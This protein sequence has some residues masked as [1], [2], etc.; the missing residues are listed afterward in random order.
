MRLAGQ[1]LLFLLYPDG[2]ALSRRGF[3]DRLSMLL[4]GLSESHRYTTHSFRTGAATAA[5]SNHTSYDD[6]KNLKGGDQG[7]FFLIS[8]HRFPYVE[9]IFTDVF[10]GNYWGFH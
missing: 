8:V 9:L 3:G 4:A 1:V 5:A 6:I 7:R 2:R 10:V